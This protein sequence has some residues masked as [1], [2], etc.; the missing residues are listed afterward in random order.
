MSVSHGNEQRDLCASRCLNSPR[1]CPKRTSS[2]NR[3]YQKSLAPS[4]L[5]LPS[6]L[7]SSGDRYSPTPGPKLRWFL[8]SL[9]IAFLCTQ[10]IANFC[11]VLRGL[12]TIEDDMSIP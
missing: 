9:T 8:H 2:A 4:P 11:L 7:R 3:S 5:S 10:Q 6:C 1:I 12:D